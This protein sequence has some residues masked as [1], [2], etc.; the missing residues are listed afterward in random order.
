MTESN[1]F[2]CE[3]NPALRNPY[4][5]PVVMAWQTRV[6]FLNDK[7]SYGALRHRSSVYY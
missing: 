3:S 2:K 6:T 7:R 5:A 4:P 1:F